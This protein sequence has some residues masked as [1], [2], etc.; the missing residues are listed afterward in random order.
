MGIDL[1]GERPANTPYIAQVSSVGSGADGTIT[2]ST[3][4]YFGTAP[5]TVTGT[6]TIIVGGAWASLAITTAG[7]A[8]LHVGTVTQSTRI[9]VQ[10][11]TISEASNTI[12][13]AL[14]GTTTTPVW[15]RGYQNTPGDQD[16]NH[17]ATAGTNIPAI[18]FTTGQFEIAGGY[19][20]F[21]NLDVS[22]AT[23]SAG[24]AVYVTGTP[25]G[26]NSTISARLAQ[27]ATRMAGR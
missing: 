21:S 9:N 16:G 12:S 14:N 4:N 2:L 10:A 19:I 5:A 17:L 3:T 11:Q 27:R 15:W 22:S 25:S 18:T 8:A 13:F 7:S 6:A 1:H 20:I 23:T 24:G 26:W